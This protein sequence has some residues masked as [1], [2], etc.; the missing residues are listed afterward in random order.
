M[1]RDEFFARWD[2]SGAAEC[3]RS[4][5]ARRDPR[6]RRPEHR[7]HPPRNLGHILKMGGHILKMGGRILKMGGPTIEIRGRTIGE[8]PVEGPET[9]GT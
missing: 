5:L 2:A 3:A 9:L 8:T 7:G 6:G 1:N 4:G